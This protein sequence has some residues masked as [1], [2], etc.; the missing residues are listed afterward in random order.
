MKVQGKNECLSF[1]FRKEPDAFTDGEG[2]TGKKYIMVE[3]I[4]VELQSWQDCGSH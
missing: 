3:K 4:I 2:L 1:V